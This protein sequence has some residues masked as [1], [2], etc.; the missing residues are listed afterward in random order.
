MTTLISYLSA[1]N[2]KK[3]AL[4]L[5]LAGMMPVQAQAPQS[6]EQF[7][8][9]LYDDYQK[10][11]QTILEHYSDF[12]SGT[13]HEYEAME[14][15]KREEAPKPMRVPDV[16]VSKPVVTPVTLPEPHLA[17]L[18]ENRN[19]LPAK[20][21]EEPE[22]EVE[23]PQ[24]EVEDTE[25]SASDIAPK[26]FIAPQAGNVVPPSLKVNPTLGEPIL[27]A[28]PESHRPAPKLPVPENDS[29]LAT[30]PELPE[31][32][33][34]VNIQLPEMPKMPQEESLEGKELIAFYGMEIPVEEVKFQIMQSM[35]TVGD[36]ARQWKI[37][38]EQ[39]VEESVLGALKPVISNLG[40]NDYLAYEFL[41]AYMDAKFPDAAAAPK[42]GAV[43][44]LLTH[45][46]YN[47][48]V[49]LIPATG[50][51]LLLL[52]TKQTLYGK[53]YLD[54]GSERYYVMAP[55]GVSALGA[56]IATCDL[57]KVADNLGKK[58]DMLIA[59]LN[60]PMKEHPFTVSHGD[61]TLSGVLNENIMPVV[62]RYP[63]METADF[64][65]SVLDGDLR[66]ELVGQMKA[67]LSG[68][69]RLA[70]VNE[71][72][73]FVQSGFSYSTDD[74]F[75]GFEKPYFFEENLYYPQNDCE[76]RAIFYT[77]MLWHAL[78]VESQLL[79]FPGHESAAVA[80]DDDIK[81]TSYTHAGKR[82]FISDPTYIGSTT[83][84]CMPDFVNVSPKIDLTIPD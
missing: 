3:L 35:A 79:F 10:F 38:K 21:P 4:C 37:L 9:G 71:L 64:A 36:F 40:L 65:V 82:W 12:L 41:S 49:A 67:Q 58:V 31:N 42:M 63:Q 30:R 75:H 80:L 53:V 26:P 45:L 16:K 70:A 22:A 6:Y 13:W 32:A 14:P 48:R 1:M 7:R 15:L 8:R 50:D 74:N 18:P 81:G 76:D 47:A 84:M 29:R 43:H 11:R 56:S 77:Y 20:M 2:K 19:T 24:V 17:S 61:I 66:N 27:A 33:G 62:Y 73:Q 23:E 57:P 54:I 69:Q 44:Y 60:F 68:K 25:S 51:P 78:G 46:G 55:P 28:L 59:G 52:P 72:L 39:T 5:M 83:G 34:I